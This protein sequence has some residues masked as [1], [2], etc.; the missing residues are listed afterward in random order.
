MHR[1]QEFV[2]LHRLDTSA[3]EVCRLL[4]MGRST[5]WHYRRRLKDAGLLVGD[6][7]DLP[8]LEV[9]KAAV[10][11]TTRWRAPEPVSARAAAAV[12]AFSGS[13]AS[14]RARTARSTRATSAGGELVEMGATTQPARSAP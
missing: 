12:E 13:E 6:A 7:A 9:I 5:E 14:T 3:R 11:A 1:L 4:G 8:P 10:S 2:R